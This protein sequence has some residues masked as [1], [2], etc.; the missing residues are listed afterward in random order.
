MKTKNLKLMAAGFTSA[1]DVRAAVSR[2]INVVGLDFRPDSDTFVRMVSSRAGIIPDYVDGQFSK[3]EGHQEN[4][5]SKASFLLAGLFS[6]DM[7]QNIVTRV[8]NYS[9]DMVVLMGSERPVMLDN[10]RHTLCPDISSDVR[11]VKALRVGQPSDVAAASEFDGMADALLFLQ[12]SP[13][14]GERSAEWGRMIAE[15]YQGRL[16]F[17]VEA[18]D[19]N[20]AEW[21]QVTCLPA[22]QGLYVHVTGSSGNLDIFHGFLDKITD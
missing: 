7:P 1:D 18:A 13:L 17:L 6:D 4:G 16:P 14:P 2:G 3:L 15:N 19:V 5:E 22:F 21:Q 11:I 10:L 9:L 20:D 8:F 12:T